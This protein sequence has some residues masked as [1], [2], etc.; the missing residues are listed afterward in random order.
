M[1]QPEIPI[2]E[3]R[4]NH[5]EEYFE[6]YTDGR[7][8]DSQGAQRRRE[9]RIRLRWMA[10][11]GARSGRLLEVGVA[12][13]DFLAEARRA[14]FDPLGIEPEP[15]AAEIARR[16]SG[17][18]VLVGWAEEV[19]LPSKAFDV[20]CLWHVLE[21]I[22]R[23]RPVL[24]AL[25]DSLRPGGLLFCEVPNAGGAMAVAEG[26]RWAYLDPGHH[27]GFYDP[28]SMLRGLAASGYEDIVTDT[29]PMLR[30]APLNAST[31]LR[32]LPRRV[33]LAVRHGMP[34]IAHH[35]SKQDL[36]RA[37]AMRPRSWLN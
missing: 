25:R 37:C 33:T 23:P 8:Y 32:K 4:S 11:H 9:A 5:D 15:G 6:H 22:P 16:R 21:H 31:M 14:G 1:F 3:L 35:P 34:V 12:R 28:G 2:D 19:E 24:E 17:V 30:Y 18:E 36:L 7:S 29:V 26:D 13:G 20:V 10:F 27:V